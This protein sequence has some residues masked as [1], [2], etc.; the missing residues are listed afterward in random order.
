MAEGVKV[1]RGIGRLRLE[2]E[3]KETR[4]DQL[5]LTQFASNAGAVAVDTLMA[6]VPN[7]VRDE[8][9]P[10]PSEAGPLLVMQSNPVPLATDACAWMEASLGHDVGTWLEKQWSSRHATMLDTGAEPVHTGIPL[11]RERRW[12]TCTDKGKLP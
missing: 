6:H 4:E 8:I 5:A 7:L 11:C 2:H 12:C 9:V 10:V 3:S 1:A